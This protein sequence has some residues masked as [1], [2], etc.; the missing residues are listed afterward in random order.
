MRKFAILLVL[1]GAAA[2]AAQAQ[3]SSGVSVELQLDQNQYLPDEDVPLK[4]R[5]V[6]RSGEPVVLGMDKQWITFDV[7]GE[8]DYAVPKLGEMPVMGPFTLLSG[9]AVTR[10]FNPTPYFAFRRPGRYR[11]G[12]IVKIAQWQQEVGCKPVSLTISEGVPLPDFGNL[13][14]GVPPPS[15]ATNAPPEAR[16]YSLLKVPYPDQI[17][18]Y[19]RLTDN[20]GR[21]L[22]V[23]PLARMVDFG[24]PEAQIDRANNLHVLF[25]TGARTFT[26]CV[27]GPNGDL[28]ARQFHEYTQTRPKLHLGED[29]QIFVGGGRRFLTWNDIPAPPAGTAKSQ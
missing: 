27:L 16:H 10:E 26:Y 14:V 6:N 17:K 5:I 21:T 8:N 12:A 1:A 2:H 15:G 20:G 28:L 19:F 13:T 25:Q 9:Q 24:E 29:V 3:Q 22:R 23:L 7:S 4:V 18:L 11:I